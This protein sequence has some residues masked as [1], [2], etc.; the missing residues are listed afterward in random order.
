MVGI[1]LSASSVKVVELTKGQRTPM[2]LERYAIEPIERGAIVDGN[3]EKTEPVADALL[4][5]LRKCN[6]R[7]KEAALALPSGAV[8]TKKIMLPA[9]MREEDYE[10]QVETEAS[11]YIPFS[12]DEVNLDFQ[13][14]GPASNSEDEVDVLLA[15]SRKEKVDDRVAVA[16]MAGLRPVVM[17]VEPYALRAAVDHVTEFLPNNGQGQIIAVFSIGQT[18]TSLTVVLNRQTIFER[19]QAFGGQQLTQDLVR[20]YGLT[21]EEAEVKKRTGDLPENYQRD[22]LQPFIEQGTTDIGRALQFFFTSTPYTRVDQIYLAGGSSVVPGLAEAVAERMQVPTEILSPFQGME[23]A[24]SIRERQLR[25]DAPSLLIATGLA[26][27][28]FDE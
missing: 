1:D 20:L 5:A 9:G 19:E 27:R 7:A 11:Q 22:L 17:D 26:M 24:D 28:R 15:A 8:I 21:P 23:V 10:V 12:I 14:L 2:R 6:S 13:L 4:R 25:A 18:T 3:I 16:E